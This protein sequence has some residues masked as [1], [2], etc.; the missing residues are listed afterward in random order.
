MANILVTNNL[1]DGLMIENEFATTFLARS[2]K[3]NELFLYSIFSV[4]MNDIDYIT[5][6]PLLYDK[7]ILTN[8]YKLSLDL[9]SNSIFQALGSSNYANLYYQ[10][11]IIRQNLA[12]FLYDEK[13]YNY[14]LETTKREIKFNSDGE[15]FCIFACYKYIT[16]YYVDEFKNQDE[17]INKLN[18]EVKECRKIGNG[19]N[20]TGYKTAIDLMQQILDNLYYNYKTI[21]YIKAE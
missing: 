3:I 20:L 6:D 17:L 15:D 2:P 9:Q 1:Y 18:E 11:Y 8:Y 21:T 10:I 14:L 13:M 16:K 4:I 7:S 19:I 12:K 5:K